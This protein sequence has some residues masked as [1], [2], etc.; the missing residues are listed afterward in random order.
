MTARARIRY[1]AITARDPEAL[2]RYYAMYFGMWLL[3]QSADGDISLT[4]GFYNFTLLK[5][6][7]AL[8]TEDA[9]LGT[10]HFGIEIADLHEVERRL[11]EHAP[12]VKLEPEPG[13]LHHGEYRV[14]DPNGLPISLSTQHFHVDHEYR[15][16]PSIRHIAL[17]VPNND[18]MLNFYVN[19]F[20]FQATTSNA[21]LVQQVPPITTRMAGDSSTALAILPEPALLDEPADGHRKS[22]FNHFGILVADIDDVRRRL[23]VGTVRKRPANRPF[24]E[25]RVVDPEQNQF[26]VSAKAGFEVDHGVWV[27][28]GT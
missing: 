23:P 27:R 19:V 16:L 6:R 10:N 22:G 2:A 14:R 3:G 15:P 24:A 25:Y 5:Q 17:S 13:G 7:P 28:S 18:A 20:G 11:A 26:D 8:G 21:R 4:D 1:L 9:V 12:D